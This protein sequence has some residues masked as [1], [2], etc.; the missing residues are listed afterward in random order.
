M[1]VPAASGADHRN[2]H[3]D[4]E[5]ARL[6]EALDDQVLVSQDRCVDALLDL[7]NLAPN[8]IARQLISEL[9]SDIRFVT[10]VRARMLRD[11]LSILARSC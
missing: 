1:S 11:D 6:I 10:A 8:R 4:Q 7:Y 2:A 9:L 3:F 5:L